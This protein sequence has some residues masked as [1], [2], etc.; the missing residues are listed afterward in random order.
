MAVEKDKVLEAIEAKFKGKSIT[1]TF[2][3]EIAAKWA[4]KIDNDTEIDAYIE[5]REDII[6]ATVSEADRRATEASKKAG[7]KQDPPQPTPEPTKEDPY[8]DAPEWF[9]EHVKAQQAE[10][11]ELKGK[12][13]GFE[14]AN[15]QKT[16]EQRFKS[17]ERLKGV[18]EFAFKGRIPTSE[19]DFETA[20]S[21]LQTDFS[22]F[23]KE[24]NITNFGNDKPAGGAPK[25]PTKEAS[26]EQVDAVMDKIKI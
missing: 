19:E 17:D 20:V 3:E 5:D 18:P 25:P 21:E 7:A 26:K 22:S 2:K 24:A 6:L 4:A 16:L 11:T 23:A 1:K 15:L 13:T 8:K 12:L 10:I 9:K 14:T